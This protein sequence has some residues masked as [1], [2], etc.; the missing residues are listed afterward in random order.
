MATFVSRLTSLSEPSVPHTRLERVSQAL[1]RRLDDAVE[2]V[3]NRACL[4]GDL[5]T[6]AELLG[7]LKNLHARRQARVGQERRIS[8]Q[9]I[10]R[11]TQE[12]ARRRLSS[13]RPG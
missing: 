5:D 12:L 7:V 4:N 10:L 3:F 2:D 9:I 13:R 11:A 6:A 8:D 1:R